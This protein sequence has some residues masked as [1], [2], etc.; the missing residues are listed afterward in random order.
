M[1]IEQIDDYFALTEAK[2]RNKEIHILNRKKI[3]DLSLIKKNFFHSFDKCIIALTSLEIATFQKI[4]NLKRKKPKEE[5]SESELDELIFKGFWEFLSQYRNV[6][7]K[8][9]ELTELDLVLSSIEVLDINLDSH[10]VLNPLNCK[11][12]LFSIDFRGTFISRDFQAYISKFKS[13]AKKMI[14]V[15][16]DSINTSLIPGSFDFFINVSDLRANIFSSHRGEISFYNEISWGK[17]N[18]VESLGKRLALDEETRFSF[19]DFFIKNGASAKIRKVIETEL[20]NGLDIFFKFIN[21]SLKIKSSQKHLIIYF[22]FYF[23]FPD[24][25]IKNFNIKIIDF[26]RWLNSNGFSI[27]DKRNVLENADNSTFVF[28]SYDYLNPH[29]AH[30]NQLLKR[31]VKWLTV[32]Q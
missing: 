5:I 25:L 10:S 23:D 9:M 17:R 20:K 7:A 26:R 24:F 28:L 31:R 19:L 4:V 32:N 18:L 1:L 3:S 2:L 15:E 8:R 14:L 21:S 27:I 29:Y 11:G 12:D 30:L 13:F 6:A 22:N 16:R